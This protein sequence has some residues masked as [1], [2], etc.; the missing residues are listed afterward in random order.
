M[1]YSLV[2]EERPGQMHAQRIRRVVGALY[3]TLYILVPQDSSESEASWLPLEHTGN[4]SNEEYK[5]SRADPRH[6]DQSPT[7][8]PFTVIPAL[9]TVVI[10]PAGLKV[11]GMIF[12]V[13]PERVRFAPVP[14]HNRCHVPPP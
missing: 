14:L 1:I 8:S 4:N 9:A 7:A 3:G 13:L 11:S 5:A 6:A 2:S 12:S 10:R